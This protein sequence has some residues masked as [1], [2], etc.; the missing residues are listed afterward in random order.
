MRFL[1][2]RFSLMRVTDDGSCDM[3]SATKVARS[4]YEQAVRGDPHALRLTVAPHA[5][6][7]FAVYADNCA[8]VTGHIRRDLEEDCEVDSFDLIPLLTRLAPEVRGREG[9]REGPDLA[10]IVGFG[11]SFVSIFFVFV[12]FFVRFTFLG[13]W[14]RPFSSCLDSVVGSDLFFF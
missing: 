2:M 5:G 10:L 3:N 11:A 6:N 8:P 1:P 12:C 7:L 13:F 14:F 9:G 4:V